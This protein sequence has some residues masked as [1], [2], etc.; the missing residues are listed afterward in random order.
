MSS[1]FSSSDDIRTAAPLKH[2][3][4]V[5]FD[6][7][8]PL[9]LGGVLPSVTVAYET[10]GTLSP[11]RDNAVLICHALSGDSHVARHDVQDIPGWWE[12][13]VGPGKH[14][15]TDKY[16]VICSNV[17]GGCRGTTGP[18]S[19]DSRTGKPYGA[20]F[21]W[22]TVADMVEA[23]KRLIDHLGIPRLLAVTGGSM[24]GHQALQW[25]TAHPDRVR[26]CLLIASS[27]R[28]T[29]QALA[30]DIVGRN[31]ILRDPNF[32]A[33]QYYD[34]E[35][36]PEVGLALARMLG[37]ITYLSREAM[38]AKFD[39]TRLDPRNVTTEFEKYF[40][41]GSYLAYQGHRFVERFD[42]NSYVVLTRAMD[43]FDLGD[44]PEKLRRSFERAVKHWLVLSFTSDWLFPSEQSREIVD[45]L[46]AN[47][48]SVSYCDIRSGCGHDAFLLEDELP[49][50][51]KMVESFLATV[52]GERNDDVESPLR[53]E[54]TDPTSIFH[55]LDYDQILDLIPEGARVL[56]LGCGGGELLSLVRARKRPA[57]ALGVELSE[58]AIL[59]AIGRGVDVV[60]HDLEKP[61]ASFPDQS[62]DI[63][64]LSQTLQAVSQTE[65][66]V[67]EMLRVGK[68]CIVSFPNFAYHKLRSM[69]ATGR[70]PKTSG[71]YH[72]EWYNTPN[73]RFGSIF[74]FRDFCQA[75]DIRI[76][77][78]IFLDTE[79]DRRIDDDPNLNADLAIFV[80]TL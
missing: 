59:A 63:V 55:R 71:I 37:H 5:T 20:D 40:S 49:V 33:G 7:A 35:H 64:L 57:R 16:F 1:T 8:M 53:S 70:A 77:R 4:H 36:G 67:R 73:R 23:Q 50:Y 60:Q 68:R 34:K 39:P 28:L 56:D 32:H 62:F 54:T 2:A 30:F 24:G 46:I 51:G 27:A 6:A 22:I 48:R 44:A 14:L 29:S 61:L 66:V 78:E 41:V 76:E 21:P 13:L 72:Y 9:E 79:Q 74:D 75:K 12:L 45:T 11:Q 58:Q 19:I 42:A 15:D 47:R 43:R 31:A 25:A 52:A 10:Y 18:N 26:S 65:G 3:K 38:T 17:L 69:L 80:L